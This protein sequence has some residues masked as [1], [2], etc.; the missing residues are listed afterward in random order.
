MDQKNLTLQRRLVRPV[1]PRSRRRRAARAQHP[2]LRLSRPPRRSVTRRLRL[3]LHG[4]IQPSTTIAGHISVSPVRLTRADPRHASRER[5]QV[6][7]PRHRV[8]AASAHPVQEHSTRVHVQVRPAVCRQALRLRRGDVSPDRV[9]A[10][11]PT[12]PSK[13][14]TPP[15]RATSLVHIRWRVPAFRAAARVVLVVAAVAETFRVA[16]ELPLGAQ[17]S[18]DIV[19]VRGMA[20]AQVVRVVSARTHLPPIRVRPTAVAAVA[21]A[22]A[23]RA[24]SVVRVASPPSRVSLAGRSVKNSR[25]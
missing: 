4:Q 8:T 19:R 17:G 23:L 11:I 20:P 5:V 9:R 2:G 3:L 18:G 12:L 15:L 16:V 14:C 10:T 1:L 21:V 22:A 6:R 25:R 7:T 24:H 13:G